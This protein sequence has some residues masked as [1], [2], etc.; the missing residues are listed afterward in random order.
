M[1]EPVSVD[2]IKIHLRLPAGAGAEDAYLAALITG[3]RAACE[4]R[5][6][7]AIIGKAAAVTLDAFPAY[8]VTSTVTRNPRNLDLTLPGGTVTSID[9]ISWRHASGDWIA[10]EPDEYIA[11]LTRAPARVAPVTS[12][13][14]AGPGPGAV[15]IT[16]TLSPL[17][18]DELAIVG[19]AIRLIVGNWYSNREADVIDTRGTPTELP[20]GVKWLLEPLRQIP[21]A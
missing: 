19:H 16:Y 21:G 15:I 6:G 20:T 13:P 9:E 18:A 4:L 7:R 8:L 14:I 1:T 11:D 17:D 5:I 10:V 12:W 2:N 3:A